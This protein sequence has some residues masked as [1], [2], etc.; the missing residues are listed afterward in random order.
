M[1]NHSI[2]RPDSA[3]IND[4][5]AKRPL[6]YNW[7]L[8]AFGLLLIVVVTMFKTVD[9]L[10]FVFSATKEVGVA[11]IIAWVISAWIEKQARE[12]DEAAAEERRR[13]IAENVVLG[14]Y[15]LHHP[16]NYVKTVVSTNLHPPI[17]RK[18]FRSSCRLE[19]PTTEQLD[20]LSI[21]EGRFLI[22]RMNCT[23]TF[24]NVSKSD[25]KF[26]I[27]F[28]LALRHGDKLRDF[29]RVCQ[30]HLGGHAL[31]IGDIND[32]ITHDDDEDF[33]SY[34]WTREIKAG[35]TFD[36][37]I[38]AISIKELS[39]NE[40]WGSYFPTVEYT[41]MEVHVPPGMRYGLRSLGAT[42]MQN[43]Y[44]S[45]EAG[46]GAWRINGP[47]LP[48]DSLVFWWRS[49]EDDGEPPGQAAG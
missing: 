27:P 46:T 25:Q 17:V 38:E 3:N 45:A 4:T 47:T 32:A 34:A 22:L 11:L 15:G 24:L 44:L 14:V 10:D 19:Y 13:L 21:P 43:T 23:Y 5:P 49:L 41:E 18:N 48:N 8:L 6:P 20:E 2:I 29:T 30:A 9:F 31:N 37:H 39:D 12:Q 26:I 40:V 28:S 42:R 1:N 36:I 33:K 35:S 7:H 16:V